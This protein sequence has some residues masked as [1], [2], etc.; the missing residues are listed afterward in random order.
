MPSPG[1][2][3]QALHQ[4]DA[5]AVQDGVAG[6]AHYAS[7]CSVFGLRMVKRPL[8]G[9]AVSV[10][11]MP[12]PSLCVHPAPTLVQCGFVAFSLYNIDG[13]V[14]FALLGRFHVRFSRWLSGC[15]YRGRSGDFSDRVFCAEGGRRQRQHGSVANGAGSRLPAAE[16]GRIPRPFR[17]RGSAGNGERQEGGR[18]KHR[19]LLRPEADDSRLSHGREAT[20]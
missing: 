5:V 16:T 19:S 9:R 7:F 3:R 1:P 13:V 10:M 17:P 8:S 14:G 18:G 6:G 11:L 20:D 12:S 2:A 4:G 15:A